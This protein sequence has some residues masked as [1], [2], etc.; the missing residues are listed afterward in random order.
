MA[1]FSIKITKD[2]IIPIDDVSRRIIQGIPREGDSA[3]NLLPSDDWRNYTNEAFKKNPKDSRDE[4]EEGQ[5]RGRQ[6]QYN[7]NADSAIWSDGRF[8]ND[9]PA[10]NSDGSDTSRLSWTNIFRFLLAEF[11]SELREPENNGHVSDAHGDGHYF[12]V[13]DSKENY[14]TWLKKD[15]SEHSGFGFDKYVV[16]RDPETGR[17]YW[18]T[19]YQYAGW[20]TIATAVILLKRFG[21]P[22]Q[23]LTLTFTI[24][25]SAH[26]TDESA[27]GDAA[28]QA[29]M[30]SAYPD[31]YGYEDYRRL[32]EEAGTTNL[33]FHGA[34][35][36]GK[37]Y[38][39]LK[40][41]A[42]LLGHD[43][44]GDHTP[45]DFF[46]QLSDDESERFGFVQ[47][48]PSYDYTDFVEGLRPS[49]RTGEDFELRAGTFMRFCAK[50]RKDHDRS[51]HYYFLIDEIN[52]GDV[53]NIFGELFF[54]LDGGYRGVGV[55][56]QYENLHDDGFADEY[57]RSGEADHTE[58]PKFS[59][60]EN[61]TIIG[62]MNDIDRSVD[63]FDFA[64][65]RRFRFIDYTWQSSR[66]CF[67][68]DPQSDT[69]KLMGAMNDRIEH[70]EGLGEEY[71]LGAAYFQDLGWS[72]GDR[73]R[74]MVWDTKVGP[75]LR[76]YLRGIPDSDARLQEFDDIWHGRP[77]RTANHHDADGMRSLQDESDDAT[78]PDSR[79]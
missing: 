16:A 36:T 25:D 9:H 2:G 3:E 52:R 31:V 72:A 47:F 66:K 76:E 57:L 21:R 11:C 14:D 29:D 51:H 65:R 39:V 28:N 64:M 17:Q 4:D 50:A 40:A 13:F 73:A 20:A 7:T 30:M 10:L 34:P 78:L 74:A 69:G 12:R 54:L 58:H 67:G 62:T 75:L 71:A 44:E 32:I 63:S 19:A 59:I 33:I 46:A 68:I 49:K 26:D 18:V 8:S 6:K 70:T 27:E 53:S 5:G 15:R 56:T 45:K 77:P 42:E 55:N 41:I 35:G 43:V 24:K 48:H 38:T 1:Q 22:G 79:D 23:S 37:T 60:P 61:V